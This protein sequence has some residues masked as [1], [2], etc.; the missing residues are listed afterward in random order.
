MFD[1]EEGEAWGEREQKTTHRESTARE[2]NSEEVK[3]ELIGDQ[4]A[5]VGRARPCEALEGV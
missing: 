4:A 5:D 3:R 1:L 2:R